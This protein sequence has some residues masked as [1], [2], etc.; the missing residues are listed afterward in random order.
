MTQMSPAPKRRM[1]ALIQELSKEL[2]LDA[3]QEEFLFL[4]GARTPEQ[5]YAVLSSFPRVGAKQVNLPA[6]SDRLFRI[7]GSR[8][9]NFAR[10]SSAQARE[11]TPRFALGA[12]APREAH[13]QVDTIVPP[14]GDLMP[15]L[16]RL[17]ASRPAGD[18][19]IDA[20]RCAPW[21]VRNQ[22]R[23]GTCVAFALAAVREA[24]SCGEG[25]ANTDLSEQLLYWATKREPGEPAPGQDGTWIEFAARALAGTGICTEVHWPYDPTVLPGNPGHDGGADPSA[26]ALQ[27]ARARA[28]QANYTWCNGPGAAA[29]IRRHLERGPVAVSLPV[30]SDATVPH[31]DNWVNPLSRLYGWVADPLPTSVVT[32]G[33]AVCI[34]GYAPDVQAPGGGY[35]IVRNSWGTAWGQALPAPG[36]H[37]PEP[38]YGQISVWYVDQFAWEYGWL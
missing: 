26:P 8:L 18:E 7:G 16:Q 17:D 22:G 14:P 27:D 20:R 9:A 36:Y 34:T 31:S 21:P 5:L 35:F 3:S 4:S 11:G 29:E 38:G 25:G 24:L 13:W 30:F 10:E 28:I 23:R 37:G 12:M 2:D 32:N 33:H 15:A 19:D 6:V 1:P